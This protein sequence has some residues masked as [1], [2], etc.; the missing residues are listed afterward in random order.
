MSRSCHN[1]FAEGT[2]LVRRPKKPKKKGPKKGRGG[3][4]RRLTAVFDLAFRMPPRRPTRDTRHRL[5]VYN[6]TVPD[7]EQAFFMIE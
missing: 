6:A 7:F 5:V 4:M 3:K 1:P 2:S